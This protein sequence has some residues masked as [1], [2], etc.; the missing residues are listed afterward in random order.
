M[1]FYGGTSLSESFAQQEETGATVIIY[2]SPL[3]LCQGCFLIPAFCYYASSALSPLLSEPLSTSI[4]LSPIS[5]PT[6]KLLLTKF[7]GSIRKKSHLGFAHCRV[8]HSGFWS[9]RREM[10]L[11]RLAYSRFWCSVFPCFP[12]KSE[13]H[14]GLAHFYHFSCGE[15]RGRKHS[16]SIF[17]VSHWMV[18]LSSTIWVPFPFIFQHFLTN[19]TGHCLTCAFFL[20][21][22][23]MYPYREDKCSLYRKAMGRRVSPVT[24]LTTAGGVTPT[25]KTTGSASPTAAL[26]SA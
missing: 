10:F 4:S 3:L 12:P 22:D 25:G 19:Q 13:D 16:S 2:P 14:L 21:G 18:L 17:V 26:G 23:S 7:K 5:T 24:P 11:W 8:L 9:R 1:H 6:L 20:A 15:N